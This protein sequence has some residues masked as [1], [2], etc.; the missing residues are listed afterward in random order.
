MLRFI[1]IVLFV[2]LPVSL[3][4]FFG[5][6]KGDDSALIPS[7]LSVDKFTLNVDPGQGTS[8]EQITDVWVYANQQF[9]GA[10]EVPVKVPLL[11]EGETDIRL[12]AGIKL[13]GI[14][15]T[16]AYYPFFNPI[17]QKVNLVRDSVYAFGQ[18]SIQYRN[19]LKFAWMEDFEGAVLTFDTTSKSTVALERTS[20]PA[21][22]FNHPGE[23]NEY[24]GYVY[25]P[26]DSSIFEAMSTEKYEFPETGSEVFLEMNY[27]TDNEFVVGVKYLA[28][29]LIVQRPLLYLKPSPEWN[30]IY[31][32][33]T[34][35][36]YD[37]PSATDFQI[38][39]GA[40]TD[41]GDADGYLLIDNIKLI[42][43]NRS[44]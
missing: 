24:S 3:V 17:L 31:V 38:F 34:V 2:L 12:M 10:F 30:K 39:I 6:K 42:H 36:K 9:I 8:A 25:L 11:L 20:D 19:N 41:Q 26:T 37:T 44:K 15:S 29:G 23:L 18:V 27:A 7:Y 43:I 13:N 1:R 35:P 4:A 5:C 21:L 32:N 40:K 14:S 28:L 33:L 22:L 16:R